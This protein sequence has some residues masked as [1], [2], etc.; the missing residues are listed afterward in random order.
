MN[1]SESPTSP[2]T[3]RDLLA[4]V[5]A[6][7]LAPDEAAR[8]LDDTVAGDPTATPAPPAA[9]RGTG[10]TSTVSTTVS[11]LRINA[12]GVKLTVVPDP[13][14]ATALV[15]GTHA[16]THD[17]GTLVLDLPGGDGYRVD[18]KPRFLGWLPGSW[19]GGFGESVTVRVNPSLP[20]TLATMAC[21]VD[22]RGTHAPVTLNVISSS[23]KLVDHRGS[24]HGTTSMSSVSI[25]SEV[26]DDSELTN[27]L[28]SLNLRLRPGSDVT[29]RATA[30]MGSL[31]V[32]G[33]PAMQPPTN[34]GSVRQSAVVGDGSHTFA[35]VV[36]MG[37]ATVVAA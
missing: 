24:L 21:S 9:D 4:R 28:G 10:T 18:S 23:F 25:V 15:D 14:V 36:R 31:K 17:G 3:L 1:A 5:A 32:A 35:L 20:L 19:A 30:E 6:G 22:A 8:L 2:A 33:S 34:D 37:S 16:I 11:A 26:T 12:T 27:E 7:D 13:L 29:V